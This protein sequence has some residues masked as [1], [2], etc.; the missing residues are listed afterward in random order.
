MTTKV[1]IN[2]FGRIGRAALKLVLDT[3]ELE[4]HRRADGPGGPGDPR[5]QAQDDRLRRGRGEEEVMGVL[6]PGEPGAVSV[7]VRGSGESLRRGG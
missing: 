7:G 3:P 5:P 4:L 2:G 6:L 1:A